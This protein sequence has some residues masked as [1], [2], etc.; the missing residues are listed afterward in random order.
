MSIETCEDSQHETIVY[1]SRD[2]PKGCPLCHSMEEVEELKTEVENI[3]SDF[4]DAD[5][6]VDSLEDEVSR[7]NGRISELE[8]NVNES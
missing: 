4:N 1:D 7:L 2:Y 3:T 5:W 8:K 6:R